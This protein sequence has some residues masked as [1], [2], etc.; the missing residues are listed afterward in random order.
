LLPISAKDYFSMAAFFN[1]IDGHGLRGGT[2]DEI[3]VHTRA[4]ASA[5]RNGSP[6]TTTPTPPA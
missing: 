5:S 6:R 3:H 4:T 2:I 1:S